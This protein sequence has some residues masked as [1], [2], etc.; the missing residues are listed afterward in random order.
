MAGVEQTAWLA[1]FSPPAVPEPIRMRLNRE[2]VAIASDPIAQAKFRNTGFE[3]VG[4]DAATTDSTYRS[5]IARWTA[6]VRE[7]GLEEK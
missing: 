6:L 7:R 4:T 2:L 5:E 3:P 1:V